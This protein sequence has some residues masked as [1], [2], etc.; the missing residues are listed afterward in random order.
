M[1]IL[2][3]VRIFRPEFDHTIEIAGR[4]NHFITIRNILASIF[5]NRRHHPKADIDLFWFPKDKLEHDKREKL[6]DITI[7]WFRR[8]QDNWEGLKVGSSVITTADK[9]VRLLFKTNIVWDFKDL[10]SDFSQYHNRLLELN[11]LVG[12]DR[13][14]RERN[15]PEQKF[16]EKIKLR[17]PKYA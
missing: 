6:E 17:W 11:E 1:K 4:S 12:K 7:F 3:L 14:V 8:D 10:T 2:L 9:Y 13:N 15:R 16:L 5:N